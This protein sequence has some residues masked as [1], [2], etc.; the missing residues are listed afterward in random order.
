MLQQHV[1]SLLF[2]QHFL[3]KHSQ[4]FVSLSVGNQINNYIKQK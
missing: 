3:L 2:G 4:I 1:T